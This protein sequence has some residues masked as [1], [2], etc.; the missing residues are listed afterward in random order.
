[1]PDDSSFNLIFF[2]RA[3]QLTELHTTKPYHTLSYSHISVNCVQVL[4]SVIPIMQVCYMYVNYPYPRKGL[5]RS[6]H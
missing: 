5:Y 2:S 1:M 4:P 3:H 6:P